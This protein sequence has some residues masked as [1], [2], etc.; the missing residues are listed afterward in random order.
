MENVTVEKQYYLQ[1]F[2]KHSAMGKKQSF[3]VNKTFQET[4]EKSLSSIKSKC[5]SVRA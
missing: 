3:V 2:Q 1:I 5:L 4:T